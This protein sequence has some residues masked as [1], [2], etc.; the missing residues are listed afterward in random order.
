MILGV[1]YVVSREPPRG[2]SPAGR[3]NSIHR[4]GFRVRRIRHDR[5]TTGQVGIDNQVAYIHHLLV[6]D[7]K[8]P[9]HFVG[10]RAEG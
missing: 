3:V 10:C 4:E 5:P 7:A 8:V 2:V 9:L 6:G 1:H